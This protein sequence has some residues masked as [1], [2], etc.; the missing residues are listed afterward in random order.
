MTVKPRAQKRRRNLTKAATVVTVIVVSFVVVTCAREYPPQKAIIYDIPQKEAF[1]V[2]RGSLGLDRAH[3]GKVSIPRTTCIREPYRGIEAV[4]RVGSRRYTRRILVIP[5]RGVNEEG[6]LVFGFSFEVSGDDVPGVR[7]TESLER[8]I[9][10]S[11]AGRAVTVSNPEPNDYLD[12]GYGTDVSAETLIEDMDRTKLLMLQG[13]CVIP[14]EEYLSI[15]EA[16]AASE[17]ERRERL[18]PVVRVASRSIH[19][20][21][22]APSKVV[23]DAET[24]ERYRVLESVGGANVRIRLTPD[25]QSLPDPDAS[26]RAGVWDAFVREY[27]RQT[28]VD[29][30]QWDLRPLTQILTGHYREQGHHR[31]SPGVISSMARQAADNWE[32]RR[33][34]FEQYGGAVASEMGWLPVDAYLMALD[35][36]EKRDGMEFFD[37]S[38]RTRFMSYYRSL[39]ARGSTP[40]ALADEYFTKPWWLMSE[41]ERERLGVRS[42]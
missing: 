32:A 42:P 23:Q 34:L 10:R 18:R 39:V 8:E 14:R 3:I 28:V 36:M 31:L 6:T 7:G 1:S 4:Y 40:Q 26:I 24:G 13:E 41:S 22:Y 19:W 2:A 16:I 30:K 11:F 15:V 33:R 12:S 29:G 27:L 38:L 37:S 25:M 17:K 9:E 35:E 21:I 5:K 20:P